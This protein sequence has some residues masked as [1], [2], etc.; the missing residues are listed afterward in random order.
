MSDENYGQRAWEACE[1]APEAYRNLPEAL[2]QASDP[3][4][5]TVDPLTGIPLY[6]ASS[7]GQPQAWWEMTSDDRFQGSCI[8][9]V[10]HVGFGM[11]FDMTILTV[12]RSDDLAGFDIVGCYRG[13]GYNRGSAPQDSIDISP[14]H[15]GDYGD[16]FLV[17][18]RPVTHFIG[19]NNTFWSH[20]ILWY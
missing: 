9:V 19:P 4:A 17:E 18:I 10:P 2:Q 6:T 11:P 20:S 12:A 14:E 16:A 3:I 1:L 8:L 13:D 15:P 5:M 7:N